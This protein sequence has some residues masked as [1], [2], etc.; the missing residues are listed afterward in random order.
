MRILIVADS[1]PP[2]KSSAAVHINDL[3][4][5][6]IKQNHTV[7][8]IVPVINAEYSLTIKKIN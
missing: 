4:N 7:V 5:E 1:F 3:C 2:M 6:L 8:V